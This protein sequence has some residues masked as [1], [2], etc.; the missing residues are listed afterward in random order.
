MNPRSREYDLRTGRPRARSLSLVVRHNV[1]T[2]PGAILNNAPILLLDEAT[3]SLDSYSE[4]RV[5]RAVDRL[6]VGRLAISVPT[7]FL[8]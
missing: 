7:V 3:S 2:S 1:A 8:H 4:A 6:A 5:Q